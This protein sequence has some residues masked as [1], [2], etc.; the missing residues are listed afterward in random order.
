MGVETMKQLGEHRYVVPVSNIR[1]H[2]IDP[3][4]RK[5]SVI[6]RPSDAGDSGSD[7]CLG[8]GLSKETDHPREVIKVALAHVARNRVKAANARSDLLERRRVLMDEWVR[9]LAQGSGRTE[10]PWSKEVQG[11]YYPHQV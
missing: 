4:R 1:R 8:L 9:Y 10:S 7:W 6:S 11:R 3:Q 5:S 2:L